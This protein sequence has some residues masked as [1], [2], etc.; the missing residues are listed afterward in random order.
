MARKTAGVA[1]KRSRRAIEQPFDMNQAAVPVEPNKVKKWTHHDIKSFKPKT[2]PQ[3]QAFEAWYQG[4]NLCLYGSAG[5]GKTS[6]AV[7]LALGSLLN[8][9]EG[10]KSIKIVRSAVPVRDLGFM[11]GTVQEKLEPYEAPYVDI[12]HQ[13]VGRKSTYKD[14]KAAGKIEFVSTSFVR[15]VTWDNSIVIVEEFQNLN[16]EEMHSVMTRI[17]EHSRVIVTGDTQQ[18]DLVGNPN[19]MDQLSCA[20]RFLRVAGKMETFEMIEHGPSDILRSGFVKDWILA[21]GT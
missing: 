2:F 8:E 16:W 15:G 4:Q 7:Y 18:T 5:T 9:A 1:A 3:Q 21:V 17:G 14:M 13:M 19:R 11:P 12:L 6:C 20:S 10:I